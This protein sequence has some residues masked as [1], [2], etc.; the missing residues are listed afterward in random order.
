MGMP[1]EQQTP[2][3]IAEGFVSLFE[4]LDAFGAPMSEE[5]AWALA[6]QAC[7]TLQR[8]WIEHRGTTAYA[9]EG[10]VRTKR[11]KGSANQNGSP[12][13]LPGVF[14]VENL[15]DVRIC[16]D[17]TVHP[18]TA[19]AQ[20]PQSGSKARKRKVA[21]SEQQLVQSVG[22]VLFRA[23]DFRLGPDEQRSLSPAM[24][25][26]LDKMTSAGDGEPHDLHSTTTGTTTTSGAHRGSTHGNSLSQATGPHDTHHHPH[27]RLGGVE[28]A[29][30]AALFRRD[31]DDDSEGGGRNSAADSE[32][33]YDEGI[34]DVEL[35]DETRS[36]SPDAEN[37]GLTLDKVIQMC[38]AH[39]SLGNQADPH[40]RAVC[41]AFVAEWLELTTFLRE[42][43]KGTKEL[44]SKSYEV[45]ATG[46]DDD[47]CSNLDELGFQD[48]A[49]LWVQ[50]IR[51]LRQ[52]VVLKKVR[53]DH[54]PQTEP[55]IEYELTPYEMLLD[56]IR[57]RRYKLNKVMVN[58]ELPPRVKKDAF[59]LILEFIRSRPP[60]VPVGQ[61]RLKQLPPKE[62]PL[63]ERLMDAI[64]QQHRLRHVTTRYSSILD[65]GWSFGLPGQG[66]TSLTS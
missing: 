24:D 34:H 41:R 33:A 56:D 66:L 39:M 22:V 3:V 15:K 53:L 25:L 48:W 51:E 28:P 49:R 6:F 47:V 21:I 2:A 18:S 14:L 31:E 19:D 59:A 7:K 20:D 46:A 11:P 65:Y 37:D 42:V 52:G 5:H 12:A 54:L 63:H 27:G 36:G 1:A 38:S 32:G 45:C 44:R 35:D 10:G 50:V 40:Y 62:P 55:S 4:I 57:S 29:G 23:L 58:G 17:G 43:S 26:L 13:A 16:Q 64:R 60:L 9:S 8:L 30:R 61:R